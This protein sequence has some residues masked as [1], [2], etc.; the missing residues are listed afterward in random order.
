MIYYY[1]AARV[2]SR[3]CHGVTSVP[4]ALVHIDL[5][6]LVLAFHRTLHLPPLKRR[7]MQLTPTASASTRIN[8]ADFDQ[9][10]REPRGRA[11]THSTSMSAS[12]WGTRFRILCAQETATCCPCFLRVPPLRA[13]IEGRPR[14]IGVGMDGGRWIRRFDYRAYRGSGFDRRFGGGHCCFGAGLDVPSITTVLSCSALELAGGREHLAAGRDLTSEHH[15][16]ERWRRLLRSDAL[17][18]RYLLAA[19]NSFGASKLVLLP[20]PSNAS[21]ALEL[22]SSEGLRRRTPLGMTSVSST[23]SA[24]ETDKVPEVGWGWVGTG[25]LQRWDGDRGAVGADAAWAGVDVPRAVEC[26]RGRRRNVDFRGSWC[27]GGCCAVQDSRFARGSEGEAGDGTL[28]ILRAGMKSKWPGYFSV[29]PAMVEK[30]KRSATSSK[31]WDRTL[32]LP[33]RYAE[34]LV[35]QPDDRCYRLCEQGLDLLQWTPNLHLRVAHP[36]ALRDALFLLSFKPNGPLKVIMVMYESVIFRRSYRFYGCVGVGEGKLRVRVF[37]TGRLGG[38]GWISMKSLFKPYF[39][40][41]SLPI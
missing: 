31:G 32:A 26:R 24:D 36:R 29:A 18:A 33:A 5:E 6:L 23:E 14:S 7:M 19:I 38:L 3:V 25:M 20:R 10:R 15:V 8:L 34:R 41:E 35:L 1:Q 22:N 37:D 9:G 28:R 30:Y 12:A 11:R 39:D 4:F 16:F 27:D 13:R 2:D 40:Q 17:R 21:M